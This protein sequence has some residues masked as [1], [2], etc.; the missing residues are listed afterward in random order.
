[1]RTL[2]DVLV[3]AYKEGWTEADTLGAVPGEIAEAFLHSETAKNV[4]VMPQFYFLDGGIRLWVVSSHKAPPNS[5]SLMAIDE[6]AF[7]A[8]VDSNWDEE[9]GLEEM[10]N[11]T[12]KSQMALMVG[13]QEF[14]ET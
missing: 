12:R 13:D 1:M 5:R 11:A 9:E 6:T 2:I 14:Y 8:V 3:S 7:L 10:I 4:K